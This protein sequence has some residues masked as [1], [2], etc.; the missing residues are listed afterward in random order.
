MDSNKAWYLGCHQEQV[1][2]RVIL[3]GDPARVPRLSKHLEDVEHLPINR[4]LAMATGSYEGV[5]VTL[6]AF[7]MGAPIAAIVLHELAVL[8]SSV[9]LRIGTSIGLPPVDIGDVVI[10]QDAIS[11]EG[12]SAAYA[13]DGG[14]PTTWKRVSS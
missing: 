2:D 1:A 7:G 4:G 12:T 3:L 14:R 8:G 6:A 9:F 10:A 13:P 5:R 11:R